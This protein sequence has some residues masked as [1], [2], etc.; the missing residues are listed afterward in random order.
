FPEVLGL[1]LLPWGMLFCFR[2]ARQS[3]RQSWLGA[4]AATGLALLAHNIGAI[5]SPPYLA[6]ALGAGWLFSASQPGRERRRNAGL[7]AVA[8]LLGLGLAA[9]LILPAL[10]E[11]PFIQS[12]RLTVPNFLDYHNNF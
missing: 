11:L 6:G 7:A 3:S 5:W 1:A 10:A 8:L 9:F 12:S 4:A 2:L